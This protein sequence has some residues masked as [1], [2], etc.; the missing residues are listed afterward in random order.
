MACATQHLEGDWQFVSDKAHD[1][2]KITVKNIMGADWMVAA[3]IPKGKMMANM[4]KREDE[5]SFKLVK[6]Q[7]SQKESP[8]ENKVLEEE[9][10]SFME[11][12]ITSIRKEGKTLILSAGEME[13]VL[14][15]DDIRK[16]H[17]DQQ[18]AKML[19]MKGSGRFG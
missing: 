10:L 2:I 3:M 5:G 18:K 9:F 19:S 1:P 7:A 4:L 15:E 16:R 8:E 12:G 14:M 6:F 17:E 13:R 11:A